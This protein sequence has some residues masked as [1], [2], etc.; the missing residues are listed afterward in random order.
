MIGI[1]DMSAAAYHADPAETPSLSASI[2]RTLLAS[3]PAHARAAHPKLNPDFAKIDDKKF[4][5]GTAV[6]DVFLEDGDPV[7]VIIADSWRT[8]AAQEQ[9]DQARAHGRIPLLDGQ[10]EEVK[11]MLTA[12]RQQIDR[13]D[14]DPPLFHIGKPEQ[15]LVWEEDGV[16]CRARLDWLHDDLSAIDDL[17]TTSHTANP[18]KW[19][20]NTLYNIG[21]DIQAAFYVRGVKALTGLEP[22]FRWIVCETYPPFAMSV[23][24]PGPDVLALANDKVDRAIALWRQCLA[25]DRWP[26]YPGR[27]CYAELPPWAESQW[28]GR[29]ARA[30]A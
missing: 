24:A 27:V 28:L 1:H 5:L 25:A 9:R 3:S 16:T 4:D 10:W 8:K 29:E 6:H 13:F 23:I 11:A 22:Q 15:T 20:R 17:K 14:A 21:C 19:T 2:A 12:L 30:A 18:E 26:A 7:E